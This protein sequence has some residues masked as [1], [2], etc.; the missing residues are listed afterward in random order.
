MSASNTALFGQAWEL[1]VT[2]A[3]GLGATDITVTSNAWE[4]GALR[5]TFE[6]LQ[7]AITSPWWFADIKVYN[8]ND[9]TIQNI[10]S[11]ATWVTLKAGFQTSPGLYS[12]IWSGP[13]FQVTRTREQIVDEVVTLHCVA[14]PNA[15]YGV[16]NVATGPGSTQS[17]LVNRM[18]K[19]VGL[20]ISLGS[21][22]SAA[23]D[24]VAYPRGRGVF[25]KPMKYMA[26]MADSHFMFAFQN[27]SQAFISELQNPDTLPDLVYEPPPGPGQSTQQTPLAAGVT[28]SIIGTPQQI[29]QGVLFTVLLDPRLQVQLPPLVVQLQ[30]TLFTQTLNLP[31]Q[32]LPTALPNLTFLVSQVR[33][34]GD[35]RGNDWQTEVTGVSPTYASNV[36][37]GAFAASQGGAN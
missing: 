14:T 25:G 9:Q 29:P 16:V 36:L 21:K 8:L 1:V 23:L 10:M 11:G 3:D 37:D 15:T 34:T 2:Y 22:A 35:T 32:G 28:Q 33:H 5:M 17:T 24:S 13:V 31:G 18:A 12:V 19:A 4:P 27:G 30:N 7:S 6:V 20:S 26:Q